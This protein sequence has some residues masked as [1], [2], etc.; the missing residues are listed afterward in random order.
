MKENYR[1]ISLLPLFG[2]IFAKL[3]YD[4]VYGRLDSSDLLNPDQS[5]FR[6]GN[7]TIN[8]LISIVHT[9]SEAFDCNP[10]LE[11]RSVYLDISKA[12]DRVWHEGLIFKLRQC[13]VTG[14]L[15]SL[16]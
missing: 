12:F 1:P 8:Q 6:P 10:T 14:Q 11:V 13:G 4:T 15:L 2:N 9:I 3:I 7:S 5:G 16:I